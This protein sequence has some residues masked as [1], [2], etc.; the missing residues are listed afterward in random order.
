MFR[1]LHG[2]GFDAAL[3]DPMRATLG[4]DASDLS[5]RSGWWLSPR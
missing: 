1:F 4:G 3:W 5:F 2:W